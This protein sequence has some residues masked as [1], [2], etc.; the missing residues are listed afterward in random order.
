M[1][2][3]DL[4]QIRRVWIPPSMKDMLHFVAIMRISFDPEAGNQPDR[5]HIWFA[6]RV[7]IAATHCSD[8]GP[9]MSM[10]TGS[11]RLCGYGRRL[12]QPS[13]MQLVAQKIGQRESRAAIRQSHRLDTRE[14]DN[15]CP[16]V[17]F[18]SNKVAK[19]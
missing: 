16:L 7:A 8:K 13:L 11:P 9:H 5:Q 18:L 4:P 2:Q 19:V 1:Y 3:M 6:E 14:P 15:L 10:S 17:R 12:H